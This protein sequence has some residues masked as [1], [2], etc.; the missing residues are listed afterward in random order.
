M[1]FTGHRFKPDKNFLYES[2]LLGAA[3]RNVLFKSEA[4]AGHGSVSRSIHESLLFKNEKCKSSGKPSTRF[5]L[6]RLGEL[7]TS[8]GICS[9]DLFTLS[10]FQHFFEIW[11]LN[12]L[13]ILNDSRIDI[14]TYLI[15]TY[16]LRLWMIHFIF[17]WAFYHPTKVTGQEQVSI[18]AGPNSNQ[19]P[20][21]SVLYKSSGKPSTRFPL[22]TLVEL[23]TSPGNSF[24]ILFHLFH[25]FNIFLKLGPSTCS[26]FWEAPP[27]ISLACGRHCDKIP[28]PMLQYL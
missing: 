14:N 23:K 18:S 9:L 16:K 8:P 19:Y 1:C 17:K 26:T 13:S 21:A 27:K 7:K 25:L 28:A 22:G 3:C 5:P 12:L 15:Q 10:V 24:L 20:I 11:I 2:L 6:G 4:R